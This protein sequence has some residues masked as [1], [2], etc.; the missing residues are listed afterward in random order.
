MA[1][2]NQLQKYLYRS[3]YQDGLWEIYLGIC[4]VILGTGFHAFQ[5]VKEPVAAMTAAF[6]YV[7]LVFIT[8]RG[9]AIVLRWAK[10]AC[11]QPRTGYVKYKPR[12]RKNR[13]MIFIRVGIVMLVMTTINVISAVFAG[14]WLAELFRWTL[15]S[16]VYAAAMVW[17]GAT[18]EIKRFYLNAALVFLASVLTPILVGAD[19]QVILFFL[20]TGGV[21]TISGSIQLVR[22]LRTTQPVSEAQEGALDE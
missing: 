7:V 21:L 20:L 8:F 10:T 1:K 11:T 4:L 14:D 5:M 13:K 12:E 18:F 15:I 16:G 3:Y 22:F 6:G 9:L 17:L 19:Q 2:P